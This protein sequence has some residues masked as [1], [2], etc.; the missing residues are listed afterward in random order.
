MRIGIDI[1]GGDYAPK[2]TVHGAIRIDIKHPLYNLDLLQH[3]KVFQ[4]HLGYLIEK[5]PLFGSW[6]VYIKFLNSCSFIGAETIIKSLKILNKGEENFIEQ[7][8]SKASYAKKISKS[9]SKINWREQSSKIIAKIN[10]LTELILFFKDF[11]Y[12]SSQFG[13]NLLNTISCKEIIKIIN[14]LPIRALKKS[15]L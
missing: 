12:K 11:V 9:E 6:A 7:D 15:D 3:L 13:V 14:N 2:K 4:L 8:H 5:G 10:A 1:M